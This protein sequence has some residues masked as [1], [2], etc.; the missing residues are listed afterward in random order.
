MIRDRRRGGPCGG[1]FSVEFSDA[2]RGL[3][4][5]SCTH[6]WDG[7]VLTITS[8]S[9]TSS[10]DLRG[11]SGESADMEEINGA[12]E[13]LRSDINTELTNY[14]PVDHIVEGFSDEEMDELEDV[15]KG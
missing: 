4:G 2:V 8:A 1:T 9:G 14:V 3:D 10:A 7:T 11:P 12:I 5:Q 6:K 15:L 13:D